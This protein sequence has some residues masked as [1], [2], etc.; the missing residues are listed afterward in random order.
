[1]LTCWSHCVACRAEGAVAEGTLEAKMAELEDGYR[2]QDL[3]L[4][5]QF[6]ANEFVD[7]Q[8]SRVAARCGAGPGPA[9]MQREQE[10][11]W[12]RERA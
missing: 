4:L 6:A 8:G 11:S 7:W 1:M 12:E 5:Q 9:C 10:L 3:A 2:R